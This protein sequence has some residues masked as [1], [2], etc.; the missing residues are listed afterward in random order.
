ML[1]GTPSFDGLPACEASVYTPRNVVYRNGTKTYLDY[2]GKGLGTHDLAG[3]GFQIVSQDPN[4]AYEASYLFLLSQ[5][6]QY[7]DK[8]RMH[9][10]HALGMSL[11]GRAVLVLAPMGGGKS[12]LGAGMLE[13]PDVKLL[14][15]D[16]PYVDASGRLHAFPLHLGL[17]EGPKIQVPER[18]RRL[19]NRME[20]G[21]KILVDYEYFS[22]RVCAS[23]DP[24]IVFLGSRTLSQ[25]CSIEPASFSA[26]VRAMISN[27][28]VGLGLFHG[29][30]FILQRSAWELLQKVGLANSRLANCLRLL[31]RSKVYYLRL[32]RNQDVNAATVVEFA[33][34]VLL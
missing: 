13:Y 10:I 23:A 11:S 6:G 30:E 16:S 27:S 18:N 14:S 24:G 4:L 29:L 22:D 3:G 28:V 33:R 8:R 1:E 21:P 17:L 9:R 32:G 20:F 7:L 2:H 34:K 25:Q 12:T 26:G 5:V 15:D 19:I 31:R